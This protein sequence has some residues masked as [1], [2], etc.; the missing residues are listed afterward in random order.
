MTLAEVHALAPRWPEP[1]SSRAPPAAT[2]TACSTSAARGPSSPPTCGPLDA[3][4]ALREGRCAP[5]GEAGSSAKLA[6]TFYS[7]AIRYYARHIMTPQ[8]KPNLATTIIQ[9]IAGDRPAPKKKELIKLALAGKVKRIARRVARPFARRA[10]ENPYGTGSLKRLFLDSIRQRIGEH[11]EL[12]AALEDGLPPL[13]EHDEMF[14]LV[15]AVN[16]DVLVGIAARDRS[17]GGRGEFHRFVR[18]DRRDHRAAV[19]GAPLLTSPSFIRTRSATSSARSPA[20]RATSIA[21]RCAVGC[22]PTRW[23]R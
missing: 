2:T 10:P 23:T 3:L 4:K 14:K 15:S 13:G 17:F 8:H 21:T 12:R 19:R 9:T 18:F 6:H 7:I 5:G 16:R 1:W 22:S 11:P 20:R